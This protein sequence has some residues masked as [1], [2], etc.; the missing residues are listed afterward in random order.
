MIFSTR[1]GAA[2][3]VRM[4]AKSARVWATALRI[5]SVASRRITSAISELTEGT[6]SWSGPRARDRWSDGSRRYPRSANE[7]ADGPAFE[8]ASHVALTHEVEH[9]DGQV[10]VHAERDRGGI[11]GPQ[12]LVQHVEVGDLVELGGVGVGLRI[13]GVDAVGARVRALQ[14]GP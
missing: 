14:Q 8:D 3:P 11:H 2:R 9:H 4:V 6:P 5:F 13:V 12:A 1:A 7:G 10:V